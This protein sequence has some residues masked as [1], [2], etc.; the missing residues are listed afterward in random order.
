MAHEAQRRPDASARPHLRGFR[1][2]SVPR[3]GVGAVS[4]GTEACVTTR[5][6]KLAASQICANIMK[7]RSKFLW[8]N[9]IGIEPEAENGSGS[10]PISKTKTRPESN[11]RV[12]AG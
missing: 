6:P 1:I 12:G 2:A 5:L 11:S 8:D 9:F 4:A 7:L 10:K 3:P